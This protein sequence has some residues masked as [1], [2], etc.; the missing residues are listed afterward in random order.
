M[1]VVC[2]WEG[3][4]PLNQQAAWPKIFPSLRGQGSGEWQSRGICRK[5]RGNSEVQTPKARKS[6]PIGYKAIKPRAGSASAPSTGPGVVAVPLVHISWGSGVDFIQKDRI[7]G[8]PPKKR[9]NQKKQSHF[10][11]LGPHPIFWAP[12]G[13][14]GP[15]I[16]PTPPIKCKTLQIWPTLKWFFRFFVIFFIFL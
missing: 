2:A 11:I 9:G 10:L 6:F 3:G 14:W 1:R 4:S 5:S 8:P 12:N 7:L 13:F 16:D 15:Q